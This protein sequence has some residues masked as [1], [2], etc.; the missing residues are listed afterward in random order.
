VIPGCRMAHFRRFIEESDRRERD[1]A[2]VVVDGGSR[3]G[4]ASAWYD[5]REP[6]SAPAAPSRVTFLARLRRLFTASV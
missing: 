2:A 1:A 4:P 5:C 6:A 3:S